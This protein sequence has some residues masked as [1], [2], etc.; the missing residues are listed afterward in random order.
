MATTK[1]VNYDIWLTTLKTGTYFLVGTIGAT[2]IQLIQGGY[3]LKSSLVL[4]VGIGLI[5]GIKNTVKHVFGI[6]M[7]LTKLKA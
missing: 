2:V 1:K 6:D 4:G 3:D 5:A 7:D